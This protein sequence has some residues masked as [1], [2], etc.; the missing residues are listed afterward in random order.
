MSNLVFVSSHA[1]SMDG[2]L[3]TS[4]VYQGDEGFFAFWECESCRIHEAI[5]VIS[6]RHA[7]MRRCEELINSHRRQCGMR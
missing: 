4:S 1:V 7:A 5:T 3:Y 2:V 6:D